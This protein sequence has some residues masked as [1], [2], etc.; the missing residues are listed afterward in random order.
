VTYSP[1][2]FISTFNDAYWVRKMKNDD[3][4]MVTVVSIVT[5]LFALFWIISSFVYI[6][7]FFAFI[8]WF[9]KLLLINLPVLGMGL[10]GLMLKDLLS[11]KYW[12]AQITISA[13][14]LILNFI[15]FFNIL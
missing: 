9:M 5:I 13:I 14:A 12:L 8:T 11:K 7:I 1:K 2:C 3:M 6:L 15:V 4:I 10:V